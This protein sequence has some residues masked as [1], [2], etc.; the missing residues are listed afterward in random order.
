M[1]TGW[2]VIIL[3]AGDSYR[4][5]R[6]KASLAMPDGSPFLHYLLKQYRSAG[7]RSYHLVLNEKV[8]AWWNDEWAET[9]PK[10]RVCVNRE[11]KKGM[12]HSVKLGLRNL[13]REA[14]VFVQKV[15]A[16]L[17][18]PGLLKKMLAAAEEDRWVKVLYQSR[19]GHPVLLPRLIIKAIREKTGEWN[20]FREALHAFPKKDLLVDDPS[21][22]WNIDTPEQYRT[23]IESLKK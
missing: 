15:D 22:L 4:M 11:V 8:A 5:G 10:A 13:G 23:F 14:F 20:N 16:P 17:T 12:L 9:W 7:C 6:M 19:G 21:I 2:G 18:D 3:A 1:D